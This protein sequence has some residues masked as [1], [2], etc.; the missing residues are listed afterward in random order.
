MRTILTCKQ[1][2]NPLTVETLLSTHSTS[3]PIHCACC[4]H[5]ITVR[6]YDELDMFRELYDIPRHVMH[7]I[8]TVIT[9][10]H[11]QYASLLVT[12]KELVIK[13]DL[14]PHTPQLLA[15]KNDPSNGYTPVTIMCNTCHSVFRFHR[16]ALSSH[17]PP[18]YCVFCGSV[19]LTDA[20]QDTELDYLESLS[21]AYQV[22]T[23]LMKTLLTLFQHQSKH[24]HFSDYFT[25]IKS[26]LA[27]I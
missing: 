13:M 27:A 1:S 7:M 22:P 6:P 11:T 3:T 10:Q 8:D 20:S 17:I 24:S 25:A 16:T 18:T 23:T 26:Q 14:H 21:A 4:T 5:K 19:S 9:E 2:P 15:T 12:L